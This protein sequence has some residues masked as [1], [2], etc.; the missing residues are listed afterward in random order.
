MEVSLE[1]G[2]SID[3]YPPARKLEH[4]A[5]STAP[6]E[7]CE[8]VEYHRSRNRSRALRGSASLVGGTGRRSATSAQPRNP[9]EPGLREVAGEA[10]RTTGQV[11]A[12]LHCAFP[13]FEK[14]IVDGRDITKM[15]AE[16][17][18]ATSLRLRETIR[19]RG[20]D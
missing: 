12:K 13:V 10:A 1:L 5:R 7:E 3:L 17:V 20:I 16:E 11:N 8:Y 19:V 6:G 15:I 4:P 2:Y 9:R 14:M 18:E